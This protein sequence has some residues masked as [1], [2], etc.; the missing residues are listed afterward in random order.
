MGVIPPAPGYLVGL[1]EP[2]DRHGALLLFDEVMTGFRVAWG[3]AQALFHLQP[4]ITCLG[5]I[6]GGGLPVGAYAGSLTLIEMISPA[7]PVYQAGTLSGNPVAMA[8]GIATLEILRKLGSYET[9]EERIAALERELRDAAANAGV[10]L[11]VNPVGST[12]CPFFV[13]QCGQAVAT[14]A[15]T[16][17]CDNHRFARFFHAMLERGVYL[18]PSRFES[19]FVS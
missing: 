6:I 14:Y 7:G 5:K 11:T 4:D 19:W 12:L 15:E 18:P 8:G 2:C 13:N 9:L 10:P 1:R 17:A 3:G 16:T